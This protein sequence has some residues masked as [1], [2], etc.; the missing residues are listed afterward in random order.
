MEAKIRAFL[1]AAYATYQGGNAKPSKALES[2]L[3]TL[4]REIEGIELSPA[5]FPPQKEPVCRHL[6][7]LLTLAESGPGKDLMAPI[8][9]LLP[10][11]YWLYRYDVAKYLPAFSENWAHAEI[12]GPKGLAYCDRLRIGLILQ[13]PN[14]FYPGHQHPAVEVY[15]VLA[16]TADWQQGSGP[17]TPKP[18]GSLILH[19]SGVPHA[20]RTGDE[21]IL[22]IFAWH[23]E[24]FELAQWC[25]GALEEAAKNTGG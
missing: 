18:P 12:A 21:P 2:S 9:A 15:Y 1:Q 25:P 13:G 19:P 23:D 6:D 11:L 3:K 14:T 4:C 7:S 5:D 17:F 24:I 8:R 22:A 10:D 16:G 20:M